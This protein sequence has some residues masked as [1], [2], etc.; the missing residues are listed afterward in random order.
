MPCLD[1][2][3]AIDFSLD[4][5]IFR[6]LLWNSVCLWGALQIQRTSSH[7]AKGEGEA[8]EAKGSSKLGTKRDSCTE[9]TAAG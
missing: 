8:Q 9:P 4:S 7:N 2:L 3:T 5:H 1:K 6:L